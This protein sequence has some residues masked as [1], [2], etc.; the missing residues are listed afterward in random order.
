MNSINRQVKQMRQQGLT[1]ASIA[2]TF[3]KSIGW[4]RARLNG[5]LKGNIT[6][7]DVERVYANPQSELETLR[8][9]GL[10]YQE[11]A[12]IHGKSINW[13]QTRLRRIEVRPS[14]EL[15]FQKEAVIPYLRTLGHRNILE[16]FKI[17]HQRADI[18]ST[19]PDGVICIT[20]VK[21]TIVGHS[22]QTAIGQLLLHKRQYPDAIT[23]IA[24]P[25]IITVHNLITQH[26]ETYRI[27]IL[28]VPT[29]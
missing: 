21:V 29:T 9:S 5:T 10:T 15:A 4:V 14:K 26:L 16:Q 18:V 23:Q 11:I 1:L 6:K 20:E 3:G 13:V 27:Y 17:D 7:N 28:P 19:A 2:E 25:D 22:M 8:Q 24:I 12:A